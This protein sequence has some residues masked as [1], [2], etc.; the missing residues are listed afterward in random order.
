MSELV[1]EAFIEIP[2]GSQNKYEYDKERGVFFSTGC[3][4]RRCIIRQTTAV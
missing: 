2:S 3:S 4:T 1:V